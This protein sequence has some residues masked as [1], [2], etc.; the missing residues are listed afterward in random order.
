MFSKHIKAKQKVQEMT[1]TDVDN[2]IAIKWGRA[3]ASAGQR[4]FL[5][6]GA[7]GK[8]YGIH[9]SSVRKLVLERFRQREE[10]GILVGQQKQGQQEM[11]RRKRYG[12]RFLKPEHIDYLT[13]A[14]TL[15]SWAGKPLAERCVLFH[16]HFGNHRINQTLL[17]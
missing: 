13:S 10:G 11:P 12:Y 16:R 4:S 14:D 1:P 5:S 2:M 9:A 15:K 6:Y 7:V 8:L 3:T 17:T